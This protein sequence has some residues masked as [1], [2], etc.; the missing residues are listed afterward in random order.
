MVGVL[1]RHG[2]QLTAATR[3][4]TTCKKEPTGKLRRVAFDPAFRRDGEVVGPVSRIGE[5]HRRV[6]GARIADV[7]SRLAEEG[8]SL[9]AQF[10]EDAVRGTAQD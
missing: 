7:Y 3:T 8:G 5:L 1:V 6:S 9:C 10:A 4:S 2:V